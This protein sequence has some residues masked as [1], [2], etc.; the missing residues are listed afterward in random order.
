MANSR[1]IGDVK[2]SSREDPA[3]TALS[4]VLEVVDAQPHI[5]PGGEPAGL[6]KFNTVTRYT[7]N[8]ETN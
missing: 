7:D 4:G 2:R 6:L 5:V 3:L 8:R 1:F